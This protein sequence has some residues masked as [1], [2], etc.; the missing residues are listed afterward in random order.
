MFTVRVKGALDVG[1]DVIFRFYPEIRSLVNSIKDRGWRYSF[2]DIVG[3]AKVNLN[4]NKIRFKL[5]YYPPRIERFEEKGSYG[6][7]AEVGE[8]PPAILDVECIESFKISISTEHAW[9][10][11]S[12]DFFKKT[13]TYIRDVL[14][15]GPR[16][17]GGREPKKLSEAREI[18]DVVKFLLEKGYKFENEYVIENYKKLVDLFE[19]KHK[20]TLTIELTVDRE[21][22]VPGWSELK[23]SLSKFFYERGLLMRIKRRSKKNIFSIF[24]KPI[25]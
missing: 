23:D 24:K 7:S 12:I 9:D 3:R 13:I 25:P 16:L 21:D 6:I 1:D 5:T 19:K 2:T 15:N 17:G 10:C 11:V 18:Y 22:M 14:W 4:L 8:K 20:F